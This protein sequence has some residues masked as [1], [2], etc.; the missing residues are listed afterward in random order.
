M[1]IEMKHIKQI[2]AFALTIVLLIG[3]FALIFVETGLATPSPSFFLE[4]GIVL[5][6]TI[7]V[8]I[9]W[10]DYSEEKRLNEK[11]ILDRKQQYFN[12]VDSVVEDVNDL[13]SYIEILNEENKKN[14][15]KNKIGCRTEKLLSKKTKW[16]CFIH[17]SYRKKTPEEIGKIRYDKLVKKYS[18]KADK[19]K[20]INTEALI[21]LSD[22]E[23]L[24]DANNYMKK[25]K[26]AFQALTTVLSA[27]LMIG[28]ACLAIKNI[29]LNWVNLF[30]YIAYL[31]AISYTIGITVVSA[32]RITG[33]ETFNYLERLTF[34]I[35]KYDDYK[36]ERGDSN[37]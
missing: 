5:L 31:C 13:D 9:W 34:I 10:Y 15:I 11:D 7:T 4:L 36:T 33:T 32:N 14:Y 22:S 35:R 6:L 19:I 25:K 30:R 23:V 8:K 12:Y 1:K 24:Y 37:D 29:M 28:L 17:P 26:F 3:L 18:R 2:L 27:A 20:P 21:S 16:L